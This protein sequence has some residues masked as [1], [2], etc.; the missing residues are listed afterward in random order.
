MSNSTYLRPPR[1]LLFLIVLFWLWYGCDDRVPEVVEEGVTLQLT[2]QAV[3][4]DSTGNYVA[5]GED[6]IGSFSYT[7]VTATL[8][9]KNRNPMP[10]KVL[11]FSATSGGQ[12]V[13]AFTP[14]EAVTD[15]KG[16]AISI[17][18]DQNRTGSFVA[19]IDYGESISESVQFTVYDTSAAVWPYLMYVAA[20]SDQIRVDNGLTKATITVRLLNRSYQPLAN[21]PV[22]FQATPAELGIL[23]SA[24]AVTDTAG[25]AVVTFEDTGNPDNV[26]TATIV[27]TYEHPTLGVLRDTVAVTILSPLQ[28]NLAIMSYPIAIDLATNEEVIVGEDVVDPGAYTVVVAQLTDQ[29]NAPVSG[30]VISFTA[31]VNNQLTGSFDISA[32]TT[33]SQGTVKVRFLDGGVSAVDNSGTPNFEGVVVR[34]LFNQ[35]VTALAQ[36]NV[37]PSQADVWPYRILLST[38]TDVINLDNGLTTATV[39]ARLLNQVNQPLQ[40]LEVAF[41]ATKGFIAVNGLTDSSGTVQVVFTDLGNPDD[42]GISR[43][44]ASFIHPSF[45]TVSDSIFISIEDTTFSGTPAYIVIPPSYPGEIMIVGGGGQESTDI[46][47]EVYDESGVLVDTP[48]KVVFTLGPNIP[49][50]ANLNNRG[51]VDSAYTV[52]GVAS[53][54]LNSG[55]GPGPVRVTATVTLPDSSVISATANPVVIVTGPAEHIFPD[56]GYESIQPI[57]GGLYQMEAAVMVYDRWYNPVADS[58]YVY[59][60]MGISEDDADSILSAQIGGTSFT[61]NENLSGES[62]AGVA[63]TTIVYP[64]RDIFSKAV[65]TALCF[66]G[67]INGDGVY[68]DSVTASVENDVVMPFYPGSIIVSPSVQFWDFTL[69]GSP[70][71]IPVTVTL[72]DYYNNPVENG[73][74]LLLA[75]GSSAIYWPAVPFEN[76]TAP[77][78]DMGQVT[79]VVEYDQGVCAPIPNTDPQLYSDFTSY[80]TATLLDPQSISSDQEEILLIRSYQGGP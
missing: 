53:V 7:R 58:T 66:G 67:D 24:L 75:L 25:K 33:G 80:I 21:L 55:T 50:G 31:T 18:D 22:T 42:V 49:A 8:L 3:A 19:K 44:T 35:E 34:A 28:Y 64:S 13:G 32:P 73:T 71:Q 16:T 2:T 36:F 14:R 45:G 70:A 78:N 41:S 62:Y 69:M 15:R 40:N 17:F 54:S 72:L 30:K 63:W 47:A 57:G 9:D 29:N 74:I 46:S 39:T 1:L 65:V 43:I 5:V 26:G 52:N 6:L 11:Q 10:N 56:V 61:G 20:D 4:L 23:S 38:N 68:G 60:T 59:W 76:N 12:T 37:Y 77:T 51:I 48:T 79:F 27:A